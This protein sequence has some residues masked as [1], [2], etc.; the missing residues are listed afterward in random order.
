MHTSKTK[1]LR[2][3]NLFFVA[4]AFGIFSGTSTKVAAQTSINL[5]SVAS[6]S[7]PNASLKFIENIEIT[8]EKISDNI[9]ADYKSSEAAPEAVKVVSVNY[10]TVASSDIEQCTKMQFK[11]ATMMNREVET[12]SNTPLYNFIDEWWAT[13]Y[14]Y[15]GNDKRGIDCS[16]FTGRVLA[17]VYGVTL[18]RTAADQYK[19]SER[20]SKE[21]LQEGDLVFFNTRGGVSHAGVYLGNNYFV[22]SSV[23]WGVTISSL[24]DD[25]YS[26]KFISGGRVLAAK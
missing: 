13:R 24:N 22:H 2:M 14:H 16:A 7:R 6:K 9:A 21:N 18:P 19:A 25:Y 10:N 12:I 4:V 26:R 11:Y 23:N 1:S 5:E 17:T 15:G 8:P 3:K 20:I